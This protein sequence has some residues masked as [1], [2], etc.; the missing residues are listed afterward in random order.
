M[1]RFTVSL[2]S[3]ILAFTAGLVTASS[4]TSD[5]DKGKVELVSAKVMEPC[6]PAPPQ[7]AA[8]VKS[9]TVTPPQG[10]DFGQNG[11]RLVPERVQMKSESLGYDIDVSY[12]QILGTPATHPTNVRKVNQ[13]LKASVTKLYQWPLNPAEA[14]ETFEA[15]SG[16]RDTVNF[17]YQVSLATDSLLSVD[18]IGYSYDGRKRGHLQQSF[19]TNYDLTS[20]KHLNLS[21][22]FKPGSKYLEFISRYCIDALSTRTRERLNSEGLAPAAENFKRW[23]ITPYGITFNFEACKVVECSAGE[24]TL[25]VS[26]SELKPLLKPDIPGRFQITYP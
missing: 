5:S 13:H 16:I 9:Y 15:R 11:L 8:P 2:I 4:W 10:I 3:S 25:T 21:D 1:K 17:T 23:Q 14:Q 26:F 22:L 19:S 20:G 18:F 6:V 24:Q 7:P 12:P